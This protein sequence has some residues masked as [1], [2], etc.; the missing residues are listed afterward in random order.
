MTKIFDPL[1]KGAFNVRIEEE[2]DSWKQKLPFYNI[3]ISSKDSH[4]HKN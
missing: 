4:K 3:Q 1:S 2:D